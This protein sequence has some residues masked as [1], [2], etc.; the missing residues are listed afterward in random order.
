MGKETK[1]TKKEDL[2]LKF[3]IADKDSELVQKINKIIEKEIKK[4]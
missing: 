1:K 3:K 4:D 2:E